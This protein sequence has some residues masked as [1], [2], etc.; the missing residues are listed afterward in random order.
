MPIV[1][2][3]IWSCAYQFGWVRQNSVQ[4][5]MACPTMGCWL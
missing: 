1:R 3:L 2:K 4:L 5:H